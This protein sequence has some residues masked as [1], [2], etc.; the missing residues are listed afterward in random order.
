[1]MTKTTNTKM[2]NLTKAILIPV[3]SVLL[4]SL[5]TKTVAQQRKADPAVKE[6]S[7]QPADDS[8]RDAYFA[9]VRVIIDDEVTGIKIN[10]TYEQLTQ[11][12]KRKYMPSIPAAKIKKA[13]TAEQFLAYKNA[14][15]YA[16]WIDDV[17][18]PNTTLDKYRA[19]SF[20][21]VSGSSVAMNAR[22]AKFPQPYQYHLYTDPY[23]DKY[24]KDAHL[25][26]L[27]AELRLTLRNPETVATAKSEPATQQ[28]LI[29]IPNKPIDDDIYTK[30]EIKPT[31]PGGMS[32]FN[33]YVA[34]NFKVPAGLKQS[35][36]II[37]QFVV[38]TDG[39]LSNI[40]ILRD[41]GCAAEATQ[42]LKDSPKWTPGFQKGVAVRFLYSLPIILQIPQ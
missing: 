16:V 1:M 19:D 5:C 31:F 33:K 6:Q 29:I 36:K 25:K 2:A 20:A 10:T 32:E 41:L 24:L 15:Q 3:L 17:H 37:A 7:T 11:E 28:K 40:Q 34:E 8:R 23:F 42:L 30:V 39:S 18:V 9:G 27:S 22:S 4:L 26:F 35:G 13:P 12:Q 38:E 21:Y 14:N